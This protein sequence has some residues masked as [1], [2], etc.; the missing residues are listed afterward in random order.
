MLPELFFLMKG[1]DL[2]TTAL[3]VIELV[4][5]QTNQKNETDKA[6]LKS[7]LQRILFWEQMGAEQGDPPGF[8]LIGVNL[9][10]VGSK[11]ESEI[12]KKNC[13]SGKMI[14]KIFLEKT[15]Y[16]LKK[17]H[18]ETIVNSFHM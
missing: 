3:V 4:K 14:R 13:I 7:L 8:L 18:F 9:Y 16:I 11:A 12:Q 5:T 2:G 10:L 17:H 6:P 1:S 15:V